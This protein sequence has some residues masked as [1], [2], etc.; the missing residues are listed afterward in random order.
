M[1]QTQ[2]KS[3]ISSILLQISPMYVK[4]NRC[5]SQFPLISQNPHRGIFSPN[6][7]Y[8]KNS[9]IFLQAIFFSTVSISNK[10]VVVF[11]FYIKVNA[12]EHFRNK[13]KCTPKN[14]F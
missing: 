7:A 11:L 6:S 5:F 3:T 13:A 9:V 4:Q 8:V 12:A 14:E 1:Y 10:Y 2:Q